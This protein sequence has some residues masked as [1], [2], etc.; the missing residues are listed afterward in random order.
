MGSRHVSAYLLD[1][2]LG[3]AGTV[4]VTTHWGSQ[5]TEASVPSASR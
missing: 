3:N 2:R 5:P 4:G 1:E